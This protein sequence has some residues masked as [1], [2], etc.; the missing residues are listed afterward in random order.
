[1]A[2]Y[3]LKLRKL[4]LHKVLHADDTPHAIALG[5]GIAVLVAFF[6]LIGIQTIIAIAL[7]AL[8]RANKVV[9][10][11][12][13]WITNPATIVPIFYGCF[14]VGR[15]IMPTSTGSGETDVGRLLGLAKDA[16]VFEYAFWVSL[17]RLL[18]ELGAELW[19]GCLV[20]GVV[21]G[22]MSYVLSRWGV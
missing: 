12:V 9:C 18:A 17:F 13:V 22:G 2:T 14:A 1:M 15:F 7:A 19:V 21:F 10:I 3:W 8:F 5:V 20:L 11:P 16:S 6:P 4:L